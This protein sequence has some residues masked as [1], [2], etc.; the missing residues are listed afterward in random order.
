MAVT[1]VYLLTRGHLKGDIPEH[2]VQ[3]LPVPE[4]DVQV[5]TGQCSLYLVDRPFREM[6]PWEG[7]S[8]GRGSLSR[9]WL[10]HCTCKLEAK[11]P[12]ARTS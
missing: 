12:L 10:F 4:G 7:H 6:A 5:Q 9:D 1:N 11:V 2:Q 3:P 8:V